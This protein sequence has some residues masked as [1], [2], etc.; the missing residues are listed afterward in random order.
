MLKGV[1]KIVL[2]GGRKSRTYHIYIPPEIALD[3]S[4]PFRRGDKVELELK[5]GEIIV[6]QI[7]K[8][9]C[10]EVL[11]KITYRDKPEIIK[12]RK[13]KVEVKGSSLHECSLCGR[14]LGYC[15]ICRSKY[16]TPIIISLGGGEAA[17]LCKDCSRKLGLK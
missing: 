14:I 8:D 11:S 7:M 17:Y 5:N 3:D 6:R 16:E 4:F 15:P 10:R 12:G 1:G 9:C 2:T 13:L